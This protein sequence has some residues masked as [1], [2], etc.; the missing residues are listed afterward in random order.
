MLLYT[1]VDDPAARYTTTVAATKAIFHEIQNAVPG[2]AEAARCLDVY[3]RGGAGVGA[4]VAGRGDAHGV[5]R[6]GAQIS[7][8]ACSPPRR[9]WASASTSSSG[10][11]G[12]STRQ[13]R[14]TVRTATNAGMT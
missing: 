2:D 8:R 5:V 7:C 6:A 4:R 3:E 10:A 14:A 1:D 9:S 11:S 13:F 12:S